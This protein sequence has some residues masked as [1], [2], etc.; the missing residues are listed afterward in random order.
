MLATTS[1][2]EH[3]VTH[4]L[5]SASLVWQARGVM[6]TTCL[7]GVQ[8]QACNTLPLDMSLQKTNARDDFGHSRMAFHEV[9]D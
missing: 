5:A 2:L 9:E 7:N 1:L 8:N 6:M 4:P 3:A